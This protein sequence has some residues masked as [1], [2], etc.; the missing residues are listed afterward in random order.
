MANEFRVKNGLI[1]DEVS[2]GAGVLSIIDSNIT[3]DDG[4]IEITVVD[5]QTLTL[6]QATAGANIVIAPHGTPGSEKI[7]VTN[8]A[9]TADDAIKLTSTAGGLTLH[10]GN[11]SLIIDADGTDAD[12]LNIDSAG[13]IDVDAADEIVITTTSADGHISLVSAHVAGD[14]IHLDGNADVGSIVKIDAGILDINVDDAITID[15]ADE[16]VITTGS[17]DGHI[18]LVSA[19][20]AGQAIHL[21]GNANAGSIVD[22]DAGILDIDVTAGVT[23]DATTMSFDGTDDSNI[24]VTGSGKSLNIGVVSGGAQE[25]NLTSAGTGTGVTVQ[26]SAGDL[27]LLA[28]TAKDIKIQAGQINVI[29]KDDAA[30]AIKLLADQGTSETILISA[31]QGTNA[32]AIKLSAAAGGITLDAELDIALDANG[33]DVF[34]KDNGTVY[35]SLTNSSNALHI[36]SG[37]T[38]SLKFGTNSANANASFMGDLTV[39]GTTQTGSAAN[40]FQVNAGNT[41]DDTVEARLYNSSESPTTIAGVGNVLVLDNGNNQFGGAQGVVM[42]I[43]SSANVLQNTETWYTGTAANLADC[44]GIGYSDAKHWDT[45]SFAGSASCVSDVEQWLLRV[46]TGGKMTIGKPAGQGNVD[47]GPMNKVQVNHLGGDG[48]DGILILRCDADTDDGDLLGSIGFDSTHGNVPSSNL[49]ASAFIAAYTTEDFTTGDKGGELVFGLSRVDDDD[50]TTSFPIMKITSDSS[51]TAWVEIGNGAAGPGELRFLEDTDNDGGSPSA[52]QYAA[53]RAPSAIT[54]NYTMILPAAQGT[55]GQV[56]DIASVSGTEITLAWDTAASGGIDITG[57]DHTVVRMSGTDDI[58]DTGIT[59]DDSDN[60][61]GMGTLGCGVIT[62]TGTSTLAALTCTGAATF[63]GGYG[64]TGATISTAGALSVDGASQF[65]NTIIVGVNDTG[66]DVKFFGATAGAY[67][68]WD[69]SDDDLKLAG[70]AGLVQSGAGANTLTGATAISGATTMTGTLTVGVDDIGLDVKFF[71]ATAGSFLLWD[72]SDDA[73]E[74]T[75]STPIKIGD[76]GDMQMYHD[77]TNSYITNSEGALKIATETSGI[78]VTIGHGTS[79]VTIADNL[80]I[81]G[82]LTVSGTTTSLSTTSITIED[83]LIELGMVDGAAPSGTTSIDLGMLV[84]YY[85]TSAKK[86]AF[87]WDSSATC[88]ALTEVA[89]ESGQVMTPAAGATEMRYYYDASNYYSIGV[90]ANGATTLQTVDSDGAAGNLQIT[91]DG[92]AEL[93][94]TTITLD[95]AGDIELNAD[96]DDINLMAATTSFGSLTNNSGVLQIK[97]AADKEL[98]IRSERDM[99]FVIDDDASDSN[100]FFSFIAEDNTLADSTNFDARVGP[101]TTKYYSTSLLIGQTEFG[102]GVVNQAS[103]NEGTLFTYDGTVFGAAEVVIHITDG[104]TNQVNKMLVCSDTSSGDAVSFSNYSVL[105]SDGTT[106]L[107]TVQATITSN[108]VSVKVDA[109]DNDIVTYAVTFLA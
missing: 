107:G 36:Y 54:T 12:A 52:T 65:S 6:G 92:T 28:A 43:G 58:Q 20:V 59:I 1:V 87:Y 11:D 68:L 47:T 13:G 79:E 46:T 4:S 9:G 35:G 70:G 26:A 45:T 97:S 22:I 27:D 94:G 33:G 21:D 7:T 5:A 98:E 91:A 37:T 81:T 50:D 24:T 77:G 29:S 64:S 56:L 25:L 55:A 34:V 57:T 88:W 42:T 67:M 95:S 18:S 105:Y 62:S 16:I 108:T 60:V 2:S 103:G 15:A 10:A 100:S 14:A 8:N 48:D 99:T 96:G 85:A 80:T 17:A 3:S 90:A 101:V 89:T 74:L 61:T 38:A 104:T 78:A 31:V 73:L 30:N 93:A 109:D 82:D 69:E 40:M 66:Y 102:K 19:H 72:E 71:G 63:G 86:G 44:W 39:N 84:N 49:E 83:A 51:T 23:L 32:A 53:F 106:E 41:L 76:G 75:D